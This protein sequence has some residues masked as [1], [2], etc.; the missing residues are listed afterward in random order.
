MGESV[1]MQLHHRNGDGSHNRLENIQF[2]CANCHSQTDT[3]GGRNGHRRGER[4][5]RLVEPP[6]EGEAA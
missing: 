2:L 5:L 4:H 3:Y 1:S 6:E